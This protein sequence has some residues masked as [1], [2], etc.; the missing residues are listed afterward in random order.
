M[1]RADDFQIWLNHKVVFYLFVS[2]NG[3]RVEV[4]ALTNTSSLSLVLSLTKRVGNSAPT[5]KKCQKM[6]ISDV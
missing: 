2:F 5:F 4:K 1:L 3:L 6:F